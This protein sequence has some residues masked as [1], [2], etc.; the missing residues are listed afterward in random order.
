M[1][2]DEKRGRM[3]E[4]TQEYEARERAW[5][6]QWPKGHAAAERAHAADVDAEDEL[7]PFP[8][9][10]GTSDALEASRDA[11]PYMPPIDPPVLPGGRDGVHVSSGFGMSAEEEAAEGPAP[12]DDEDIRQQA[13]LTLGQDS[14]ASQYNLNVTVHSGVV[15]LRGSV[16]TMD[17]AD[18][19]AETLSSLQ[20]VREVIDDTTLDPNVT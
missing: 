19:V 13:V 17:E 8:E 4:N 7:K 1:S 16:G 10:G 5:D 9:A 6:D 11:E 3:N 15:H 14:L 20:G 2:E 12:V 18:S